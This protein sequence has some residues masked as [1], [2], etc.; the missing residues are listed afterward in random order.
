MLTQRFADRGQQCTWAKGSFLRPGEPSVQVSS[1]SLELEPLF[2]L[3]K[4]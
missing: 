1:S 3:Y 4:L 2:V